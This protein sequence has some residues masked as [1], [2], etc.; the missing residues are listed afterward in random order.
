MRCAFKASS[1]W[2]L[3]KIFMCTFFISPEMSFL[4]RNTF[5]KLVRHSPSDITPSA[6]SF[7]KTED[8]LLFSPSDRSTKFPVVCRFIAYNLWLPPVADAETTKTVCSTKAVLLAPRSLSIPCN[9]RSIQPKR[10]PKKHD[11]NFNDAPLRDIVNHNSS[12]GTLYTS[13]YDVLFFAVV[14]TSHIFAS[15]VVVHCE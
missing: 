15:L 4:I 8:F 11:D 7:N 13:T 6:R 14:R 2:K 1:W 10:V 5:L 12:R 3:I 9:I